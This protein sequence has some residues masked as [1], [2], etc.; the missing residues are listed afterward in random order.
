MKTIKELCRDLRK[1]E[2]ETEKSLWQ[3]LRNRNLA[4]Y[5]F[6]RQHPL[7]KVNYQG[8]RTFYIA[9]FYCAEKRL[10]IEADGPIHLERKEYDQNRDEVMLSNNIRTL[11]FTN[12]RIKLQSEEVIEEILLALQS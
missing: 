6:L 3:L 7:C 1:N 4:G 9:D 2:T 8:F 5:K 12:E 10:V 11:R